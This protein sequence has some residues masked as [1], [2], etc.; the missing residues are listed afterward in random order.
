MVWH[1]FARRT[2]RAGLGARPELA[3]GGPRRAAIV[4][5]SVVSA[6]CIEARPRV[7]SAAAC[8]VLVSVFRASRPWFSLYPPGIHL[9]DYFR[10]AKG[11]CKGS[12]REKEEIRKC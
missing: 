5:V 8:A 4:L 12:A 10:F 3:T 11:D 2:T 9:G 7:G 1:G 6:S